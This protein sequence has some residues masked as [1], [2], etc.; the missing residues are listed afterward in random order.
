MR[1]H[2]KITRA[3]ALVLAKALHAETSYCSSAAMTSYQDQLCALADRIDDFVVDEEDGNEEEQDVTDEDEEPAA[4]ADGC[5]DA[6]EDEADEAPAEAACPPEAGE[7][8]GDLD[9]ELSISPRE[10]SELKPLK[11]VWYRSAGS[12]G[13]IE[14]R[15]YQRGTMSDLVFNS[16]DG[17]VVMIRI[18]DL[19]YLKR[20]S[21][22]ELHVRDGAGEWHVFDVKRFTG[23]WIDT[24]P[25]HELIEVR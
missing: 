8:G 12:Q 13:T 11:K 7:G 5:E 9:A 17:G 24:L 10:L 22:T 18:D 14:F 19:T 25:I 21:S 2:L 3:E 20:H 1:K 23:D 15:F 16:D 4:E 6:V